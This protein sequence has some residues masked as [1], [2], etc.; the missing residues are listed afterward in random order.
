[1]GN[2][3][4]SDDFTGDGSYVILTVWR[5]TELSKQESVDWNWGGKPVGGGGTID[6]RQ[7]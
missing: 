1:M 6:K 5:A 7:T 3:G 2:P 4:Y